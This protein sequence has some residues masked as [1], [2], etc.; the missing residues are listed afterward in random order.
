MMFKLD[1]QDVII[2]VIIYDLEE[3]LCYIILWDII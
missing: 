1:E 3:D 2:K